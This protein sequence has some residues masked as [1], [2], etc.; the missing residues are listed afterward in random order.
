MTKSLKTPLWEKRHYSLSFIQ[1]LHVI[2]QHPSL[3]TDYPDSCI[4]A[5]SKYILCAYGMK[6]NIV[7][8]IIYVQSRVA[9]YMQYYS[10]VMKCIET[11]KPGLTAHQIANKWLLTVLVR[12]Y[13]LWLMKFN[14]KESSSAHSWQVNSN[15]HHCNSLAN[16]IYVNTSQHHHHRNINEMYLCSRIISLVKYIHTQW[17]DRSWQAGDG[18]MY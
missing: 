3:I 14:S 7:N 6:Q 10:I 8:L 4:H 18:I 11:S 9:I 2:V 16:P 13:F 12:C 1:V 5:P 17:R 15:L